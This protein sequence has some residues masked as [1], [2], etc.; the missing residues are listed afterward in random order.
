MARR[1][2]E[3]RRRI[4]ACD[5]TA[6]VAAGVER[7]IVVVLRMTVKDGYLTLGRWAG[8]P[9]RAHWSLPVGAFFFGGGRVVPGFWAGFFLIVLIHEIGHALVVRRSRCQVV[10]IDVHGLGGV[11]RWA[12]D[13]TA[14]QRAKIA[15][16]GVNAQM[17]ALLFASLA[18]FVLGRPEDPFGAQLAHA[19]TIGN[20]WLIAINLIP[21]PP[22]DG[23]EAWRLPKLLW[24]R[25]RSRV[26]V[27][28]HAVVPARAAI[29]R[30]LAA[31]D[32]SDRKASPGAQAAAN[33]ALQRIVSEHVKATP[34]TE[35]TKQN[36]NALF[37]LVDRE[38]AA[39][40]LGEAFPLSSPCDAERVHCAALRLGRGD[41]RELA[42]I[43]RLDWRDILVGAGFEDD[44]HAHERWVPRPL[45]TEIAKEWANGG[46]AEGARF[47]C[48]DRAQV[49]GGPRSQ[50]EP[51]VIVSLIHLEPEPK[52]GVRCDSG[53]TIEVRESWL[54]TS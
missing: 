22:L 13:P 1:T 21:V 31:L 37:R 54:L 33:A 10:S 52:Y 46:A 38:E 27:R 35:R 49:G 40:L 25:R 9:V 41:V 53:E 30:E 29:E 36:L 45:T 39:Q 3:T 14:I 32:A 44:V 18:L 17:V 7:S 8:A 24:N 4:A 28:A 15:W 19:F 2:A 23:A 48:G 6:H 5:I 50:G 42:E 26:L 43:V 11:C 51:C 34:L 20:V 12:G 47:R 16:G